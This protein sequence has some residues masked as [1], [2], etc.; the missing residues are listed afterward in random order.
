MSA[1]LMA[2]VGSPSH[3]RCALKKLADLARDLFRNPLQRQNRNRH[4]STNK[5]KKEV[6]V[7]RFGAA[8]ASPA[9]IGLAFCTDEEEGD[10][11][12]E[13][14]DFEDVYTTYDLLAEPLFDDGDG[15]PRKRPIDSMRVFHTIHRFVS[16]RGYN[17]RFEAIDYHAPE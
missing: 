17:Y 14:S 7:P 9:V 12:D 11:E 4:K 13:A 3:G 16:A 6:E 2:T 5:N 15:K 8:I 1:P 10:D